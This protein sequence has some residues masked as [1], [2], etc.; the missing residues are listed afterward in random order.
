MKEQALWFH[1]IFSVRQA[2]KVHFVARYGWLNTRPTLQ[3]QT[4]ISGFPKASSGQGS[5]N[6]RRRIATDLHCAFISQKYPTNKS[7]LGK[8]IDPKSSKPKP[9]YDKAPKTPS[10][11]SKVGRV[12]K[13]FLSRNSISYFVPHL[14]TSGRKLCLSLLL[15][16]L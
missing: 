16:W 13:T 15:G 1:A 4:H 11:S 8:N 2:E 3:G 6:C 5:F 7:N 14:L 10:Y 9:K 12:W